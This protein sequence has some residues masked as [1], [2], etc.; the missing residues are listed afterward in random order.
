MKPGMGEKL[1]FGLSSLVVVIAVVTAFFLMG[2]PAEQRLKKFDARRVSDLQ[3]TKRAVDY[4]YR[5]RKELPK[6]IETVSKT[7]AQIDKTDP[8]TQ[9]PYVYRVVDKETYELC[10]EFS[11][12]SEG[13]GGMWSHPRGEHC[14]MFRTAHLKR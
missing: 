7:W 10:A 12:A 8:E 13:R 11:T 6:D 4:Y 2:S 14:F 9:K 5:T 1:F 3:R